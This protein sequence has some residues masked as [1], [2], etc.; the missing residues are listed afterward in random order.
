[1]DAGS[2][3]IEEQEKTNDEAMVSAT[4]YRVLVSGEANLAVDQ[5]MGKVNTGFDGGRVTR[6]QLVS[7]ILCK[8]GQSM[9]ELDLQ[10]IRAV[11]FDRIAYFEA[12]L[13]RAKETGAIPPELAALL[14]ASTN[15]TSPGKKKRST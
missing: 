4:Q 2:E 5:L 6:P 13:K 15:S 1:M 8:Y 11:H 9:T 14:P 12:L 10:E 7:W 3:A